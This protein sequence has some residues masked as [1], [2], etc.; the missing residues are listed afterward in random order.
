[1]TN[2][3][4]G[5]V[6]IVLVV[7]IGAVAF[8]PAFVSGSDRVDASESLTVDYASNVSVSESG[9]RYAEGVTITNSS[10]GELEA[11]SD[12]VWLVE[13]G[14]IDFR[15][16][17]ATTSGETVQIEYQYREA[18]DRQRTTAAIVNTLNIPLVL[19][20]FLLAGGY[21]FRELV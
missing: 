13:E 5:L 15:N 1:M 7:A 6:V 18:G 17:S 14:A 4:F 8:G 9:L 21:I 12:Y 19:V 2:D 11:D 16:T 10:G 3:L 20:I